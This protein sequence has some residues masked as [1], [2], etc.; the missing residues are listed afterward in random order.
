MDIKDIMRTPAL[1][2]RADTTMD[3]VARKMVETSMRCAFVVDARG[4]AE[5]LLTVR[6]F[7]PHDP[8]NPL[9][10]DLASRIFGKSI[11]KYGVEPLYRE[12]RILPAGRIMRPIQVALSPDDK[13]EKGIDLMLRHDDTHLPVLKGT[14]PVGSVSRHDLLKAVVAINE[15][16]APLAA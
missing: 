11:L 15:Q 6:D 14:R 4:A 5:G 7:V 16:E 10:P 2:V 12:A 1:T 8:G 13:I 9:H 3:Q